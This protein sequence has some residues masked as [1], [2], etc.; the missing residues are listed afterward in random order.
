MKYVKF[1]G[2]YAEL[3]KLGY[4]FQKLYARNYLQW[5]KEDLRVWKVGAEVTNDSWGSLFGIILEQLL[6]LDLNNLPFKKCDRFDDYLYLYVYTH[7]DRNTGT[8]DRSE[9]FECDKISYESY[10]Q[11]DRE[12][13]I[14]NPWTRTI[15]VES[16][17]QPIIELYNKGWI[18]VGVR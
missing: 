13:Y 1:T 9:W 5:N 18:E 12:K 6:T 15:I 8:L 11:D 16:C 14:N 3:K 7:K 17:I 4:E 2:K 10:Q